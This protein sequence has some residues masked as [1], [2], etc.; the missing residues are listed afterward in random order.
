MYEHYTKG[1]GHYFLN[2]DQVAPPGFEPSTENK[3]TDTLNTKVPAPTASSLNLL[4]TYV[5]HHLHAQ[6]V[7]SI[8]GILTPDQE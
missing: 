5:P 3:E 7:S 6:Q 2:A 4:Q 1:R 8:M